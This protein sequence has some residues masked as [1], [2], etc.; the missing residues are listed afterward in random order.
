MISTTS[1]K[2][3]VNPQVSNESPQRPKSPI[4]LSHKNRVHLE[5]IIIMQKSFVREKTFD[6]HF[7]KSNFPH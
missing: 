2:S 3:V 5:L 1:E 6:I 7:L 4:M